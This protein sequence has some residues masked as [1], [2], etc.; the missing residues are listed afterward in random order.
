MVRLMPLR[1]STV[2]GACLLIC[3]CRGQEPQYQLPARPAVSAAQATSSSGGPEGSNAPA[4]Q[5]MRAVH[6]RG[7]ANRRAYLNQNHSTQ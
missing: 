1:S 3:G 4:S 6:R 7:A 5:T 2:I